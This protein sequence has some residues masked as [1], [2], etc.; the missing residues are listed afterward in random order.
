MLGNTFRVGEF[1][2]APLG[3][4]WLKRL[5]PIPTSSSLGITLHFKIFYECLM[6]L[7]LIQEMFNLNLES[8]IW[9]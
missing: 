3:S 1:S 8:L 6:R 4:T 9:V 2:V 7:Y 5:L